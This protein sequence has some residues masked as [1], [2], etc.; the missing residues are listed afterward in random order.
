MPLDNRNDSSSDEAEYK[1]SDKKRE[2]AWVDEGDVISCRDAINIQGR[3]VDLGPN[4]SNDYKKS[5]EEKYENLMGG[6]PK[7]AK[8][9]IKDDDLL[10]RTGSL[11][12]KSKLLE[13]GTVQLQRLKDINRETRTEGIIR[14]VLFHPT[15]TVALVA[16]LSGT[17]SIFQVDGKDNTKLQSIQFKRFPISSAAFL[18][19]GEEYLVGSQY[20]NYFYSHDLLSGKSFKV[21]NSR[22]TD[23]TNTKKLYT[24]PDGSLIALLGKFGKI[25]LLSAVTKELVCTLKMNGNVSDLDFCND[26]L[27]SHGS[28]G[29]VYIWD[30]KSRS[31]VQKFCDEG[32]IAGTS[33][34]AS[35]NGRLLACG[36]NTGVVNI[37]DVDQVKSSNMP[38]AMKA[39]M[40]LVTSVSSL[41]FNATS[42]ILC[43]L[44]DQKED[45]IKLFHT[46][47][48]SVFSNFPGFQ[49]K[50]NRPQCVDFST[51]SGY[52]AFGNNQQKAILYRLSH[53]GNY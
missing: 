8:R 41:K 38:K 34:A 22:V 2:S 24:T 9:R 14:S 46:P 1:H 48:L 51:N 44:S 12:K 21:N 10:G 16:G 47:S 15:S 26:T 19:N 36:S 11:V 28:D 5:L 18:K 27:Y 45:A 23:I 6:V 7:W 3:N 49:A 32:C 30:L 29:E 31:C 25:Y 52:F 39:V 43:L 42:E 40:N 20:N 33:I 37:Y 17:A 4:F 35:P 13:K 50:F 53:Y